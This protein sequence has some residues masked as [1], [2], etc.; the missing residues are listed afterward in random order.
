VGH[1][2]YRHAVV[3]QLVEYLHD[4]LAGAAVQVAGG[5]VGAEILAF[6]RTAVRDF[7]QTIVMVTHDPAAACTADR[8]VFLADGRVVDELAAPT[9]PTILEHMKTLGG[10]H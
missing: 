4:R 1:E 10:E 7:H 3:V 6:M 2:D 5:L 8:V 9:V